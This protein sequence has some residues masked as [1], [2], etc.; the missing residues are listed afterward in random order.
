MNA[1]G[2]YMTGNSLQIFSI[3]MVFTLFKTPILAM[4]NLQN[5]FKKLESEGT[6]EKMVMVKLVF[7]AC[8]LMA[9]GLGVWKVDKMGLLP[10]VDVLRF[11]ECEGFANVVDRTT[12][13]DWLAWETAREPLERSYPMWAI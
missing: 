11:D 3:F 5:T 2:M 9:L 10:Y 4:L 6:R 8:N 1:I 13:S 7:V 12:R